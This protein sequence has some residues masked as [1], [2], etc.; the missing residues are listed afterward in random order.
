MS[1][2]KLLFSLM[3]V[4]LTF[5]SASSLGAQTIGDII[6]VNISIPEDLFW[7]ENT[8]DLDLAPYIF[9]EALEGLEELFTLLGINETVLTDENG[10]GMTMTIDVASQEYTLNKNGATQQTTNDEIIAQ[11]QAQFPNGITAGNI[12]ILAQIH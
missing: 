9:A 11:F 10:S 8:E 2:K 6:E 5:V 12:N 1:T 7:E 3:A 4:C